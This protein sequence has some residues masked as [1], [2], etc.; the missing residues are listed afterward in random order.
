MNTVKTV[1]TWQEFKDWH[2]NLCTLNAY[3]VIWYAKDTRIPWEDTYLV[4]AVVR[5]GPCS[6]DY[7]RIVLGMS[8]GLL[9]EDWH[10]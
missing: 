2:Y 8:D 9:P 3:E 10:E 4:S 6:D 7:H 5:T 1:S